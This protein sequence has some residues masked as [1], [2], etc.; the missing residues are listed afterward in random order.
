MRLSAWPGGGGASLT[1]ASIPAFASGAAEV[2]FT[3]DAMGT[4]CNITGTLNATP[5]DGSTYSYA[6]SG[7]GGMGETITG[8]L[9]LKSDNTVVCVVKG[10]GPFSDTTFNGTW[11]VVDGQITITLA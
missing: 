3:V 9:E 6:L 4:A 11:A 2:K 5:T 10:F 8:S 7:K 1:I